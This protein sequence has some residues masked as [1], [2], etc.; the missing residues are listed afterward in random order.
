MSVLSPKLIRHSISKIR[1]ITLTLV[2]RIGAQP[3]MNLTFVSQ[4]LEL[5]CM[6]N[7][8]SFADAG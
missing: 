6:R 3:V 8:E 2:P 1:K 7:V 5:V 4:P